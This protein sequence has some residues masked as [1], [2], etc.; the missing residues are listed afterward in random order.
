M[1]DIGGRRPVGR[2][3]IRKGFTFEAAHYFEHVPKGHWNRQIH[4]HSFRAEVTLSGTPAPDSGWIVD[5]Q[6]LAA[7][8]EAIRGVL[9]HRLLNEIEDLPSPSL[10]NLA[11]WIARRLEPDYP[12][13][14][15]VTVSRPSC[16]E[17]A[18]FYLE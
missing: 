3:E 11:I 12:G 7:S 9:D 1:S 2:L 14:H 4:G 6:A 5:L 15:A 16:S 17:S 10:E 8:L 13:L 18:T